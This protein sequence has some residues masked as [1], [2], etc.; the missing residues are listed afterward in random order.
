MHPV[1]VV[2]VFVLL[3]AERPLTKIQVKKK[4]KEHRF[5]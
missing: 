1:V 5:I 2:V 3:L 4:A